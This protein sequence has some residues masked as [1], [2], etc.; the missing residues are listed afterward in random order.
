MLFLLMLPRQSCLAMVLL[1]VTW[2]L[3][4]LQDCTPPEVPSTPLQLSVVF[5]SFSLS[6]HLTTCE[7]QPS[8]TML[9]PAS[10]AVI[11]YV[12]QLLVSC[13]ADF[14]ILLRHLPW[15]RAF[16]TVF[17]LTCSLNNMSTMTNSGT[18]GAGCFPLLEEGT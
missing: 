9:L 4:A 7:I 5:G 8:F 18:S 10:H 11:Y 15:T 12:Q 2:V 1:I 16:S 3:L 14:H 17:L 13:P 6:S